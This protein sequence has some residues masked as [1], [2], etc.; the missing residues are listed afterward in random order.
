[1]LGSAVWTAWLHTDIQSVHEAGTLLSTCQ[2]G[3][4][5]HVY[6]R[7]HER[8]S[9][10][11]A[12]FTS[13]PGRLA[14]PNFS[15][16]GSASRDLSKFANPWRKLLG[17]ALSPQ[18]QALLRPGRVN[19][20]RPTRAGPRRQQLPPVRPRLPRPR[21][22]AGRQACARSRAARAWPVVPGAYKRGR[23]G[24]PD[25]LALVSVRRCPAQLAPPLSLPE[26]CGGE[27]TG[28]VPQTALLCGGQ[29]S[30]ASPSSEWLCG[31]HCFS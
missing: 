25:P 10:K 15:S 28:G 3:A 24:A 27:C 22:G 9:A 4:R 18:H 1:M 5:M 23:A 21:P 20:T 7:V 14:A 6:G 2:Q 13:P 8:M 17:T 29:G 30:P 11:C 26:P 31:V 12:Q 19:G 16:G